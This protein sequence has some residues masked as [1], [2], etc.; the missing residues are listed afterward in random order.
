[1]P[2]FSSLPP[3]REQSA[4]PISNSQL[5]QSLC[6][7]D[8]Y[9]TFLDNSA[10]T[11]E[12]VRD[13]TSTRCDYLWNG[14]SLRDYCPHSCEACA[15]DECRDNDAFRFMDMDNM[16]CTWVHEKVTERCSYI[17]EGILV[18]SACAS[19]CGACDEPS[20]VPSPPPSPLYIDL[21]LPEPRGREADPKSEF[22]DI[23]QPKPS[24]FASV[25]LMIVGIGLI[26]G[27]VFMFILSRFIMKKTDVTEYDIR[28]S[29]QVQYLSS[30]LDE[31]DEQN[32]GYESQQY[33]GNSQNSEALPQHKGLCSVDINSQSYVSQTQGLC[34]VDMSS[35]S[36]RSQNLGPHNVYSSSRSIELRSSSP[37]IGSGSI[38]TNKWDPKQIIGTKI[39]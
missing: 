37:N 10:Y 26:T 9:L 16:G 3:S 4:V 21:F 27:V 24:R 1:M 11:C 12:W 39:P 8:E 13:L 31:L 7:D 30:I 35:L 14:A 20:A 32:I 33:T 29:E 19:A 18:K 22:H 34:G 2:Y 17:Y 23:P 36:N 15:V 28:K 38:K 25:F 5:P 6:H